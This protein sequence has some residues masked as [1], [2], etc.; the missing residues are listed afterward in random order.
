MSA[1]K[2]TIDELKTLILATCGE[3]ESLTDTLADE[4]QH[5]DQSCAGRIRSI[6]AQ[7]TDELRTHARDLGG[8]PSN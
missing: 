2:P 6:G 3:I 7:L 4:V 8:K 5:M 1:D